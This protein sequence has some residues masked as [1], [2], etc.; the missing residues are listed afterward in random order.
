MAKS[1]ISLRA[2]ATRLPDLRIRSLL[3]GTPL[4]LPC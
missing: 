3:E 1:L 4:V 2:Q